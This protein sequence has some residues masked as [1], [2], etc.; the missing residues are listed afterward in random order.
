MASEKHSCHH[1]YTKFK[2]FD[3]SV[4]YTGKHDRAENGVFS[5]NSL[6]SVQ[7]GLQRGKWCS[8]SGRTTLLCVLQDLFL[9]L[10]CLH[11]YR[12]HDYSS[13]SLGLYFVSVPIEFV[14]IY[15]YINVYTYCSSFKKYFLRLNSAWNVCNSSWCMWSQRLSSTGSNWAIASYGDLLPSCHPRLASA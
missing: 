2:H 12:C 7:E 10:G 15:I 8:L 6:F 9:C 3:H 5:T 1:P 11:S 13:F 14:G 4:L